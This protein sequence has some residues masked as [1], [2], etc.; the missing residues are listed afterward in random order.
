[1]PHP[2]FRLLVLLLV[3]LIAGSAAAQA[4][5]SFRLPWDLTTAQ[6]A[7]HLQSNGFVH[8]P[9]ASVRLVQDAPG[10]IRRVED[11]SAA[12]YT[13]RAAGVSERVFV[14]SDGGAPTQQFY[15]VI[16]DSATLQTRLEALAADAAGR[17]GLSTGEGGL[18]VWRPAG[19]RLVVPVRPSRLPDG[20]YQAT[21][22]FHR[23]GAA[24]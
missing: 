11:A 24:R 6:A 19:A 10:R 14:R 21:V 12:S 17:L 4:L 18:R 5:P 22:L 2:N 16:G 13:R 3:Q 7:A 20:R 8:Q 9:G 1:M 23:S 15:T